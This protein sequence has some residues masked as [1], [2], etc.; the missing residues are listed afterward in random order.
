MSGQQRTTNYQNLKS[1]RVNLVD[2]L[3]RLLDKG[4]VVK[5]EVILSVADV[6]L[7]YLNLGLLLSSVK[8]VLEAAHNDNRADTV[9][10]SRQALSNRVALNN[11]QPEGETE[12]DQAAVPLA[13][14]PKQENRRQ[15]DGT[16]ESAKENKQSASAAPR[17]NVNQENIE[18]GLAQLVL[19]LVDLIRQLMEKQAL[20][21]IEADQLTEQEI[22][23][24]GNAFFLLAEK[25][26]ELKVIFGISD[27]ELKIDLGPLGE[28]K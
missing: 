15:Q 23:N 6:D 1:Q 13:E 25:M 4:V 27:E 9:A 2:L 26:E 12:N 8:T 21:R 17:K 18:K 16:V 5:G 22:E 14:G 7:V 11:P 10:Y 28:L 20:R 3:D 24:V 19:T